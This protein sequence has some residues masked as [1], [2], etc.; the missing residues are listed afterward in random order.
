MALDM[1]FL[2]HLS[3][4]IHSLEKE[5]D[6]EVNI[7]QK[8]LCWSKVHLRKKEEVKRDVILKLLLPFSQ[9]VPQQ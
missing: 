2:A 8:N 7:P 1:T 5:E 4:R 6:E 9:N 3:R